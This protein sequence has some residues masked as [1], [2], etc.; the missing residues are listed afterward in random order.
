MA[1]VRG[2]EIVRNGLA[3]YLDAANRKSYVSGSSSWK[4][5]SGNN[6]G[7]S[8]V[9]TMTFVGGSP[10]YFNTNATLITEQNYLSCVSTVFADASNYT[11]ELWVKSRSS[12][13][14]TY[15]SLLGRGATWP[16]LTLLHNDTTGQNWYIAFRETGGTYNNFTS[17]TNY[18]ISNNWTSIVITSDAS[19]NVSFYLN[20]VFKE[21]KIVTNNTFTV[22]RIAGGYASGANY[23]S[24]QGLISICRIYNKTL[25]AD[26]ILTNYNANKTRFGI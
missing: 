16:W 11:F 17:I 10:A 9:G 25:S 13:S 26:E 2:P 14:A 8:L 20:G 24:L 4:D 15:N 7:G 21:T 23:Y 6:K 1:L 18:N 5:L 3:L 22:S 12:P 19:R